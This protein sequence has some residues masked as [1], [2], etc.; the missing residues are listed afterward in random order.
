MQGRVAVLTFSQDVIAQLD[1][2][3]AIF[4]RLFGIIGGP[5]ILSTAITADDE[6]LQAGQPSATSTPS[7]S[8]L[9]QLRLSTTRTTATVRRHITFD[10]PCPALEPVRCRFTLAILLSAVLLPSFASSS[11]PAALPEFISASAGSFTPQER[12]TDAEGASGFNISSWSVPVRRGC[13][14]LQLARRLAGSC[15]VAGLLE[16]S[17]KLH[18]CLLE[19]GQPLRLVPSSPRRRS[20]SDIIAGRELRLTARTGRSDLEED[21]GQY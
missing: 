8:L 16:P 20:T 15:C 5:A 6:F 18:S 11:R 3:G 2:L 21:L 17:P 1:L 4:Q 14:L 9:R 12:V 19:G 10:R 7:S 13:L